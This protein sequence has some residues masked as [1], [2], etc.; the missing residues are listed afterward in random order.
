[1][2]LA[3]LLSPHQSRCTAGPARV[4]AAAARLTL[5]NGGGALVL[6][7]GHRGLADGGGGAAALGLGDGLRGVRGKAAGGVGGS[8]S[9][10]WLGEQ[11]EV[12]SKQRRLQPTSYWSRG[13][14]R[15]LKGRAKHGQQLTSA[16]A[17]A[18]AR[19]T[20]LAA[21]EASALA[22]GVSFARPLAC[23]GRCKCWLGGPSLTHQQPGRWH[24]RWRPGWWR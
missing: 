21:A 11:E 2:E 17:W 16:V 3:R 10:D 14:P 5:G 9:R 15:R 6:Q 20:D 23:W 13:S 24:R 8:R 12:A 4:W 1:M 18:T 22:A 19:A 7:R